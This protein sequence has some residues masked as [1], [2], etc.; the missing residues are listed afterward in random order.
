MISNVTET[1]GLAQYRIS[2]RGG[3]GGVLEWGGWG[4]GDVVVE[5]GGD[6]TWGRI[7]VCWHD[8]R[9][10]MNRYSLNFQDR[11]DLIQRTIE[12]IYML[13]IIIFSV[14]VGVGFGR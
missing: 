3:G 8:N 6:R 12:N 11:W 14:L 10:L 5:G 13:W 7:R 4:G 1:W 9:K 2:I